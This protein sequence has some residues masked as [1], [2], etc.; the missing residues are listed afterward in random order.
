MVRLLLVVFLWLLRGVCSLPSAG[1]WLWRFS[2]LGCPLLPGSVF[3]L[4]FF[5]SRLS[6]VG[7]RAP[8]SC[9]PSS[10]G[11]VAL[12]HALPYFGVVGFLLFRFLQAVSC[13]AF[14][15]VHTCQLI[16]FSDVKKKKHNL[17]TTSSVS[18]LRRATHSML[19][20]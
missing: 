15:D 9:L 7:F 2:S 11:F 19:R 10:W 13:F 16:A 12:P 17:Q 5:R 20:D 1:P 6:L 3:S 18:H 8:V 14:S 4:A